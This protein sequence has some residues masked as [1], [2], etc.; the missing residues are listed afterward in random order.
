MANSW[1][2]IVPQPVEGDSQGLQYRSSLNFGGKAVEDLYGGG[3]KAVGSATDY[4]G[5]ILSGNRAA[6][7]EGLAPEVKTIQGQYANVAKANT[8][9]A[10]RGGG[11]A[12]VAAE[13]PYSMASAIQTLL[14]GVR[15]QAAGAMS[16]IGLSELGLSQQQL[17]TLIQALLQNKSLNL[18]ERGQNIGIGTTIAGDALK[19]AGIGGYKAGG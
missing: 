10:P 16:Q 5:K 11:R 13:A 6:M 4:W 15:P 12:A 1:S 17:A 18:N 8:M 14:Q 7:M 2:S 3:T 19:L 9:L